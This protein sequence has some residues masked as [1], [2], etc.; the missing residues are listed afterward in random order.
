MSRFGV[1][2]K[3]GVERSSRFN[4][5]VIQEGFMTRHTTGVKVVSCCFVPATTIIVDK[6]STSQS[7]ASFRLPFERGDL[8]GTMFPGQT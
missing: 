7:C 5:I 3:H 6:Y 2:E 1:C 4:K 8:A